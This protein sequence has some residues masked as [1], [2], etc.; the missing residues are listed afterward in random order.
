[1][2]ADLAIS[3]AV[4]WV[5]IASATLAIGAPFFVRFALLPAAAKE[6]DATTHQRLRVA[7]N[8]RWSKV[9]YA[10]IT[11]FILT[12]L[13][14]FM[15]TAHWREL[16]PADRKIYHMIFGFKMMAA[17]GI[18]FLASALAGKSEGLAAIRKHAKTFLGVLLILAA[19]VL[20]C[21]TM[22]RSLPWGQMPVAPVNAGG[23]PAI[24]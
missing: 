19:V 18:F 12:G 16:Q 13:Y 2:N 20:A 6:L 5:H 4:R 24:R 7:V 3:M 15:V 14:N 11:L 9:V 21:S 8:A 17:F 22:L 10:L 1:M 23:T